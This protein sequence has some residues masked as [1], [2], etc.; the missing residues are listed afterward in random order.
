MK[1]LLD[2]IQLYCTAFSGGTEKY[3]NIFAEY[4][5]PVSNRKLADRI[6]FGKIFPHLSCLESYNLLETAESE[7]FGKI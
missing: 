5:F 4:L 7:G 6:L 1:R 2:V 3:E